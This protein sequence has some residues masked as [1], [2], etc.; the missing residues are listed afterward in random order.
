MKFEIEKDLLE[1]I[2]NYLASKPWIEV[3]GLLA[4][5]QKLE[6]ITDKEESN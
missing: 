1:K 2:A 5:L 3:Q 4:E 6:K